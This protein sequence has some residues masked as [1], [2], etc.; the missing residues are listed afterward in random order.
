MLLVYRWDLP[1]DFVWEKSPEENSHE[2]SAAF[3]N[4]GKSRSSREILSLANI[5]VRH[6][7]RMEYRTLGLAVRQITPNFNI[8]C[9]P[10]ASSRPDRKVV[11][12]NA[13]VDTHCQRAC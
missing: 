3:V 12:E 13:V 7:T 9:Q 11:K 4:S 6:G 2:E 5:N 8:W 1:S 10:N